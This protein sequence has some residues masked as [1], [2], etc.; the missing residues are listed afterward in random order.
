MLEAKAQRAHL[1]SSQK[2][3]TRIKA[4]ALS[5]YKHL[6]PTFT[7][8]VP[9]FECVSPL[10][11][12]QLNLSV[13]TLGSFKRSP[14]IIRG[15][16]GEVRKEVPARQNKRREEREPTRGAEPEGEKETSIYGAPGPLYITS[17]FPA[18]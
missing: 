16:W 11:E 13:H 8:D 15:G 7:F 4:E 2:I 10:G 1:S 5:K 17:Y 6:S 14:G 12:G 3:E 18:D 9:H